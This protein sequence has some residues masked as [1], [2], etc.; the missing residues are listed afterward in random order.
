MN[1]SLLAIAL[2]A[3]STASSAAVIYDKDGTNLSVVGRIQAVAYSGNYNKAGSDDSTLWN[4]S[5][6]GLAGRP[7]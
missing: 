2:V 7:M 6:F 4:S 3:F 1:K 5:R